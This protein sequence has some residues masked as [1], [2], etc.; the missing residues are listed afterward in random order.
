MRFING[1]KALWHFAKGPIYAI[2]NNRKSGK[3][4]NP[5]IS[6]ET[7]SKAIEFV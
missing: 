3:V 6:Y 4:Q 2:N 7:L 1:C 5:V